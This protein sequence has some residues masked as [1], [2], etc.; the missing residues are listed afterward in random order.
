MTAADDTQAPSRLAR[1]RST[2]Y[3]WR[4]LLRHTRPGCARHGSGRPRNA[5]RSWGTWSC[6]NAK[7]STLQGT[8]ATVLRGQRPGSRAPCPGASAWAGC[9]DA[10]EPA[11]GS[12]Q[13]KAHTLRWWRVHASPAS[14]GRS[15][16]SK[17]HVVCANHHRGAGSW[18][19][20]C[21]THPVELWK[22]RAAVP[23]R[24]GMPD[25]VTQST[26]L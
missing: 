25:C 18:S 26:R 6:H 23:P 24:A 16:I 22:T 21:R 3:R 13:Q 1:C 14:H 9:P 19:S 11:A 17:H 20:E 4:G 12:K 5:A 2:V 10:S 8:P 15:A 7:F